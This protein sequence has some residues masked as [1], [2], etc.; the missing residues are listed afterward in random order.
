MKKHD[1][2]QGQ[3]AVIIPRHIYQRACRDQPAISGLFITDIGYYPNAHYHFRERAAGAE[4][5]ILIYCKEGRG[6]VQLADAAYTVEPGECFLIP[7]GV[8]HAYAAN[9]VQPWT[10]YWLHFAGSAADALVEGLRQGSALIKKFIHFSNEREAFFNQLYGRLERGFSTDNLLFANLHLPGF[11]A[12]C[13]FEEVPAAYSEEFSANM[14]NTAIDHMQKR[15]AGKCRLADLATVLNVSVSHLCYL[16]K[17]KTGFSPIEYF[18]H[19]KIQQAC[20]YLLFTDLRVNEVGV[21]LGMED[22]YYFSRFFKRQIGMSPQAYRSR[23]K[24]EAG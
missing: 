3:K 13:L 10:I 11:L 14:I 4:Q 20:Q 7:R 17:Q 23:R 5:H 1:G 22:A 15:L 18:N 9:E 19:L 2:F 21:R 6:K 12:D 24:K 8:P 16:F